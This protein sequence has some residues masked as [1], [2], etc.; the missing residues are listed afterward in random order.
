MDALRSHQRDKI[1]DEEDPDEFEYVYLNPACPLSALNMTKFCRESI[2]CNKRVMIVGDST[3]EKYKELLLSRFVSKIEGHYK[4]PSPNFCQR[5]NT[6]EFNT[7]APNKR[8]GCLVN[9]GF[10]SQIVNW[11][12]CQK[13]CSSIVTTYTNKTVRDEQSKQ[14][15]NRTIVNHNSI[16]GDVKFKFVRHNTVFGVH[17]QYW[18]KENHCEYWW[19]Q[20]ENMDY[21]ML[22]VGAHVRAIH[23]Y[24]NREKAPEDF[25]FNYFLRE[26]AETYSARLASKVKPNA[27][28]IY[29]TGHA[30]THNFSRDCNAKP[31]AKTPAMTDTTFDWHL[32]E[33]IQHIYMDAL[34][35][36][37]GNQLVKL[38]LFNITASMYMC[39]RDYLHFE[40]KHHNSPLYLVH[41]V[42]QNVLQAKN[43][44]DYGGE[45]E[46]VESLRP[47]S[48]S[49][50]LAPTMEPTKLPTV[51]PSMF[52][53][54]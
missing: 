43:S 9:G 54:D 24:P 17:G 27:T 47:F 26:S 44:H 32:I 4:C 39:R 31:W 40:A 3:V 46:M 2:G 48:D 29:W 12:M 20:V 51:E 52:V 13:E 28:V 1:N 5:N 15:Y 10:M 34:Q 37:L 38:N 23:L 14:W 30:G 42:L 25:D 22:G 50:T 8:E 45:G 19:D 35:K 33:G 16:N 21:I 6:H 53:S 11:N 36:H 41:Q 7:Q 49:P 18:E